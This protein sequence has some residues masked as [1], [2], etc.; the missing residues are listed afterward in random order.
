MAALAEAY[1][2]LILVDFGV[3]WLTDLPGNNQ[4]S[5]AEYLTS[6]ET[7]ARTDRPLTSVEVL[8][9]A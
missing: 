9:S 1:R 6:W 7:V 4:E 8:L 2:R 3:G 5:T